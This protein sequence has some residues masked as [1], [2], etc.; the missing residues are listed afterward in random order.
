MRCHPISGQ[1]Y[2]LAQ[3]CNGIGRPYAVRAA[4]DYLND[5]LHPKYVVAFCCGVPTP[6][7]DN[8]STSP[9]SSAYLCSRWDFST[10]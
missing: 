4:C 1:R 7:L 8:A 2:S 6:R 10:A 3:Q 5:L 9:D